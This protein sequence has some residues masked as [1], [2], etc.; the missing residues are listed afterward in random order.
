[1]T[2]DSSVIWLAQAAGWTWVKEGEGASSE[3]GGEI[4]PA[5]DEDVSALL[6]VHAST[7]ASLSLPAEVVGPSGTGRI[8]LDQGVRICLLEQARELSALGSS[9]SHELSNALSAIVGWAQL[10]QDEEGQVPAAL[11]TIEA[12]AAL[13][14]GITTDLLGTTTR[15]QSG[16]PCDVAA[17]CADVARFLHPLASKRGVNVIV[18][19]P[20]G[21]WTHA[22]RASIFRIAWNLG[23][24][25]VQVVQSGGSV[26]IHVTTDL[27]HVTLTVA[28]DGPGMDSETAARAFDR[29]FTRRSGGS[30]I[31]LNTV[32]NTVRAVGGMLAL[33]SEAGAGTRFDITLPAAESPAERFA[34]E[35]PSG[36]QLGPMPSRILVVEDDPGI[37]ELIE[38]TMGLRGVDVVCVENATQALAMEGTFDVGL[39]DLSLPDARGDVLVQHLASQGTVARTI[40]MSG[41]A[42]PGELAA[43]PDFWLAKPFDVRELTASLRAV[44]TQ[45]SVAQVS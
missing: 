43:E 22:E 9:A 5:F 36:M 6:G 2:T 1:M 18:D 4:T 14:H 19:A 27:E 31:G 45:G 11:R 39:V 7:I 41:H 29:G 38:T 32:Q 15:A 42:D 13:A 8:V 35:R 10:A 40:L 17:V 3:P 34:T 20:A 24:N 28:D 16:K 12:A 33:N 21:S 23:L 26:R 37:R 30:G 25:S 44:M